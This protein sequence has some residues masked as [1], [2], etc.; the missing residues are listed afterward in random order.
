MQRLALAT[1]SSLAVGTL[2]LAAAQA[3]DTSSTYDVVIRNGRVLD[4]LG[5][6]WINADVAVANGRIAA[7]GKIAAKGRKEIDARGLYVSPGWID[8]M[9]QS[10]E[11]L[12]TEGRAEN[13]LLQGVTTAI[14]GEG[15]TPVA[16]AEIP[17]YFAQLERQ[18]IS[19]N[20][21]SYYGTSQARVAVMGD[22]AGTPTPEQLEKMKALVA[23]AMRGGAIG[24]AT[25]LIYPP[26]SFQS[27]NDLVELSKVAAS[28]GGIYASHMR[29]ESAGLLTAIGESIEIGE[30]AGIPIEIF[31]LKGAYQPGWHQLM[32]QA[33]AQVDAARERGV[34]IA[35]D[36]YLYEAGGTGLDITVPSWVFEGGLKEGLKK[37]KSPKV[38]ER[39]KREVAAGSMPGWSNL[40]HSSGGW[41][42]VVLAN[43]FNPK[44]DRFHNQSLAAIG[45]ALKRD[46]ADV[47]W[48]IVI[49]AQPNRAM[50]L[51]FM[52]DEKDIETA[53]RTPWV[54]LGSDA[55]ASAKLNETDA[56]GLPHPRS[57]GNF[58]RLIAEYV[59]KRG[60]LTLPDAIRKMTS[61]PATRMRQFDRGAIRTGLW[62]D[63]TVFDYDRIQD[64][65][66]YQNPTATAE[67]IQYVVVN[68][69][70]VVAEG[71]HTGAKPG[72]TLKSS[73]CSAERDQAS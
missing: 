43:A 71:R 21:G 38:R 7:V 50:A 1:L 16:A 55:S 12:R 8:M 47:A 48:D 18:G 9:D 23:T 58:P 30:R 39:L 69:Q 17:A 11:V 22:G 26:D 28:C 13:K 35:A 45:K 2:T 72:V 62:A 49:E 66:T 57:Y 20:F 36:M 34:D 6:P 32:P 53:L 73:G 64:R 60:V 65:A 27:T 59:R 33:I 40:V 5:N 24:V 4:G 15:G 41:D 54:S 29:D 56:L 67:G 37:L 19:L 61:W 63:I 31:H 10:G 42:R 25:A 70:V 51:Y 46:P 52:M 14:A 44:Y 3:A 68:G